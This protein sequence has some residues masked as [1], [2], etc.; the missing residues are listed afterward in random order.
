MSLL[1]QYLTLIPRGL[2]T[3]VRQTIVDRLSSAGGGFQVKVEFVGEKDHG[4]SVEN[5]L[6]SSYTKLWKE[7]QTIGRKSRK[8]LRDDIADACH[9]PVGSVSVT[10]KQ[11]E[12]SNQKDNNQAGKQKRQEQ[13]VSIGYLQKKQPIW[14]C[15]GEL[16]GTVWVKIETNCPVDIMANRLRFLGPLLTL[17]NIWEQDKLL[18]T[19]QSLEQAIESMGMLVKKK[20]GQQ[21][22]DDDDGPN[23]PF[24]SALH[25]WHK[26]VESSWNLSKDEMATIHSKIEGSEAMKY[27]LSC[28][29]D[30]SDKYLYTRQQFMG[31][32][33]N[34]VLPYSKI[35]GGEAWKVDLTN[36]DLDVVL[37]ARQ[38]ALA[39]GIALKPYRQLGVKGF[40][41]GHVAPDVNPPYLPV[42]VRSSVVRLRPATAHML[43]SLAQL[44]PGDVV[45]DPCSGVGTIPMEVI[46]H[47]KTAVGIGGDVV[48]TPDGLGPVAAS[49]AKDAHAI[50]RQ[51]SNA[52]SNAACADQFAWDATILPLR[53]STVDAVVS[54]LPFGSQCLSRTKLE[55]MLPL[56]L[57][58]MARVL[59][60]QL[61]RLVLLCGDY[62]QVVQYL[63][64][65]NKSGDVIEMPCDSIIPVNIG[66]LQAWVVIARRGS[67]KVQGEL[68]PNH[69]DRVRKLAGK[70]AHEQRCQKNEKTAKKRSIQS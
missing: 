51:Q 29:R 34:I 46:F 21:K 18:P 37:L 8:N 16:Q 44:E 22:K 60:P 67:S 65:L 15:P 11:Q 10:E 45:L 23:D 9:L 4:Q 2:Q 30:A 54:D 5:N 69:R 14:S 25:L 48:L 52:A 43:L 17:I 12:S 1:H 19:D 13:F 33:A 68:V 27:R 20:G 41:T 36:Y 31:K 3:C 39:V 49:Y 66:G 59:R 7:Q 26:H 42:E 61:G 40:A 38:H 53:D 47:E 62:K 6:Q 70:R 50:Q 56:I 58:E 57:S 35:P 28:I 24:I 64:Q 63:Q 55:R 32:M